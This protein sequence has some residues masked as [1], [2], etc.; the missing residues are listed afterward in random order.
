MATT[1]ALAGTERP[2]PPCILVI[3]GAA[4]DLTKRKL[5]PALYNLRANG[6]L[7]KEFAVVGVT[8]KPK[9]HEQFRE[10]QTRDVLEFSPTSVDSGL[11][12]E[13]ASSLYYVAGEFRDPDT[14]ARLAALLP[15]VTRT[16]STAGNVLFYMAT[17]PEFFGDIVRGL[18]AA[19]LARERRR[20]PGG[21]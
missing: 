8:R 20:R 2:T 14:Y 7:A 16:H 21:G 18:A 1:N 6:L 17:P 4:G 12:S 3:F 11:W 5:L 19:G 13:L 15:E 10:E 9:T